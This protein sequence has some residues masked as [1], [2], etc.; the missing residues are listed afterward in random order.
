[1]IVDGTNK[2]EFHIYDQADA[3][4]EEIGVTY[5]SLVVRSTIT[6]LQKTSVCF[7]IYRVMAKLV[8]QSL[9]DY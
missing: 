4:L 3:M 5:M 6:Q 8:I 2:T 9:Y 1:M 7:V